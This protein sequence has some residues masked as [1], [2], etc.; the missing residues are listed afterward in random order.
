MLSAFTPGRRH[1]AMIFPIFIAVLFLY[2]APLL[3]FC[4]SIFSSKNFNKESEPIRVLVGMSEQLGR[5][6]DLLAT[7]CVPILALFTVKLDR[8]APFD[9]HTVALAFIFLGAA[10]I[11][12]VSYGICKAAA[13]RLADYGPA[14]P[15]TLSDLLEN[16]SRETLIYFAV[17]LGV[18]AGPAVHG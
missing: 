1:H 10:L 11:S 15:Q 3:L 13:E 2:F 7:I 17:M 9:P 16:Y 18:S 14:Y 6:R 8:A 5:I 12:L 4:F